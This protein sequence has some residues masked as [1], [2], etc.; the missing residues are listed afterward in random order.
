[1]LSW[2]CTATGVE[3]ELPLDEELLLELELLE[4]PEELLLE[5][6]LLECPEE[7][8]L[9]LELLECPEELLLEL[10]LLECPEELLLELE[11]EELLELPPVTESDVT[12]GR[13]VPVPQNPNVTAP[14]LAPID[15]LYDSGVTVTT[16][17]LVV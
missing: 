8:L 12:V 11:L 10:E 3:P 6:E 2:P 17:P 16:F 1:M 9:E 14:P 5:L 15:A 4:C 13:P 7:L